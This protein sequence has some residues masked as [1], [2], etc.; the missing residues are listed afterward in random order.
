MLYE[1]GRIMYVP[2]W[3]NFFASEFKKRCEKYEETDG[4]KMDDLKGK[5][6]PFFPHAKIDKATV[7]LV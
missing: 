1:D 7:S 5:R 3:I 4:P 6:F 2:F